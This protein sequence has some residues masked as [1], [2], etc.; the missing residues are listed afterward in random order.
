M[1]CFVCKSARR[2]D[3]YV[4]MREAGD[5]SV[6]PP[7]LAETLGE[8]VPVM[9]LE[10]TPDRKLAREN[11]AVVLANLERHGYHLQLPPTEIPGDDASTDPVA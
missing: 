4:F 8:L 6:L 3:T 2:K 7:A 5:V 1:I 10:L 11:P 9:E